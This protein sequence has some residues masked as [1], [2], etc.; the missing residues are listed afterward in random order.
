[1]D[2]A[3]VTGKA[4]AA[5]VL[6]EQARADEEHHNRE[7]KAAR[8]RV[9]FHERELRRLKDLAA[10]LTDVSAGSVRDVVMQFRG[11]FTDS[12]L[13]SHL[14][15]PVASVKKHV[16]DMLESG[17]IR[18]TGE[19]F[20]R[21]AIYEFA[22]PEGPG[23]AFEAQQRLTPEPE[24]APRGDFQEVK[25][26]RVPSGVH[27]DLVRVVKEAMADG[28]R[29][30]PAGA[31]HYQLIRGKQKVQFAGTPRNPGNEA[32]HLKQ[33]IRRAERVG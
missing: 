7:W 6:L 8:E 33:G 29:C 23:A 26:T 21:K 11:G 16:K 20:N 10:G 27:K 15:V 3:S 1:M 14:D 31:G 24:V 22:E 25:L 17:M 30:E 32:T 9:A 28:W 4:A 18:D 5:E 19:R 13:A 12:E 2:T